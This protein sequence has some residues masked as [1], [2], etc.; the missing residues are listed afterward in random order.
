MLSAIFRSHPN[1]DF[2]GLQR[3]AVK[4]EKINLSIRLVLFDK[5]THTNSHS[6][7]IVI[8]KFYFIKE[9]NRYNTLKAKHC[10]NISP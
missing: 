9:G 1:D 5:K 8:V 3:V 2:S 7:C 6:D 10:K 4:K